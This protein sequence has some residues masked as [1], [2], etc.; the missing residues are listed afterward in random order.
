MKLELEIENITEDDAKMIVNTIET[1]NILGSIGASREL[2]IYADG[3][4]CCRPKIARTNVQPYQDI[5]KLVIKAISSGNPIAIGI[6]RI[7]TYK[8]GERQEVIV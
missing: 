5:N 3:D 4:G 7:Y 1:M 2:R 8:N 6:K